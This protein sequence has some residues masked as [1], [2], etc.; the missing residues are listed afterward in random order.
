MFSSE[1]RKKVS[2]CLTPE[3]VRETES[4]RVRE[5]VFVCVNKRLIAYKRNIV[6]N[7][8]LKDRKMLVKSRHQVS[9]A[10][11]RVG[12]AIASELKDL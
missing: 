1:S 8:K 2:R 3:R 10:R 12:R 11:G 9:A 5:T 4:E 7:D 6:W